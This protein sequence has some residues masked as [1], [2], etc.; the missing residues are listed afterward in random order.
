MADEREHKLEQAETLVAESATGDG[1]SSPVTASSPTTSSQAA[2]SPP[3]LADRYELLS[4]V[5]AGA[6][7]SV[8]RARD[9]ELDEIVAL[10]M[11]NP[12]LL[13]SANMLERF[14]REVK[15]ARR[16]AHPSVARVH[17][18]GEHAG[19]KFLTME[20]IEGESLGALLDRGPLP[21]VARAVQL[22][23]GICGGV[24][25]AHDAGV[26]HRDLKPDNVMLTPSGRPVV[27]DFGIA[28]AI[29][30]QDVKH[31]AHGALVGTP[32]YM[33]PEQVEGKGVDER[34]D[35]YALGVVLFELVTGQLP[36]TG[37]SPYVVAAKRLTEDAPD[38]RQHRPDLPDAIARVIAQCL[39]R[40]AA[41][42]YASAGELLAALS[43]AAPTELPG[44]TLAPARRPS[45]APAPQATTSG[46]GERSVAVLPFVNSGAEDDAFV[47]EG[48]CEDLVDTLSMTRGLRVRPLAV[49]T[50]LAS[51]VSDP[52]ALGRQLGV[53]VVASGSVRRR[54]EML[55][56]TV[57]L[58]TV[59]DGFQLWAE[60]FDRPAKD[61]L[62]VSDEVA[63]AIAR[64]L[65]VQPGAA[66]QRSA[67][68][69]PLA[70]ELYL[71]G[72]AEMRHVAAEAYARAMTFFRQA[73]E[74]AP[75]DAT[76]LA[77]YARACARAWFFGAENE[78]LG[79]LARTLSEESVRRSPSH[80]ESL[81]V[82]ATVAFAD[83]QY[84]EAAEPLVLARRLAP[85]LA[86]AHELYGRFRTEV[87]PVALGI[88]A[89][90]RAR[91]LDPALDAPKL[92][93]ARISGMLGDWD[94]VD[95]VMAELGDSPPE[96]V[97]PMWARF[98]LW[99]RGRER[100]FATLDQLGTEVRPGPMA[101]SRAA[102]QTLAE[103][104]VSEATL[105]A[106]NAA[107]KDPLRPRR[108]PIFLF[109]ILA[110]L[111]AVVGEHEQAA[112][113][114]QRSIEAG[115]I[116]VVWLEHATPLQGVRALSVFGDLHARVEQRASEARRLLGDA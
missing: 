27:T 55:R 80:P 73:H 45:A 21:S 59:S 8:Y 78:D 41:S 91:E 56:V 11:L 100:L 82:R 3:L 107:A 76:I 89:L 85:A 114:I 69:D 70:I 64:A 106:I 109:Q 24:A 2:P 48:L 63:A 57:R 38:P 102:A 95:A 61:A 115:L 49:V 93:L 53:E 74:R 32:A 36:F 19:R 52:Q 86:E 60:R 83:A 87:G 15:L 12:D 33:A 30:H 94:T 84:N 75:D 4:L 18:I 54:G 34:T 6:M 90:R 104:H 50:P 81:L 20:F 28:R 25:A 103:G 43:A 9:R 44:S 7:G 62:V 31:T 112:A 22:A 77:A 97:A 108:F 13:G 47:A 1:A 92:E 46:S 26:V 35:V 17:D 111:H 29:E 14:R 5:G 110:E 68:T 72:R 66:V 10:K 88:P 71:R 40:D 67:P 101:F 39:K 99:G 113:A 105:A 58:I 79:A 23:L 51:S 37:D 16:V 98:A 42:R 116:D 65:T 96:I